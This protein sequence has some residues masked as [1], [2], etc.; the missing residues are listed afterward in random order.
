MLMRLLAALAV[1]AVLLGLAMAAPDPPTQ[2]AA[3]TSQQIEAAKKGGKVK[4][5]LD[6]DRGPIV[7]ELDGAAAPITVANFL[8]L[9]KLGLYNGM[10]FHRVVP[11]F[12]IQA[13]DPRLVGRPEVGYTI[14]DEKSPLKHI[15]GAIAMARLYRANQMVPN[16]AS[17]Q[18]YITLAPQPRLDTLGFTVF[19]HVVKGMEVV[20]KIAANDKIKKAEVLKK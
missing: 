12:V 14:P 8:N 4:V 18:F 9:V 19:G 11:G 1:S 3:P 20:E 17:T 13:G 15:K 2:P 16:S 7:L 6:T 5:Q 10:P